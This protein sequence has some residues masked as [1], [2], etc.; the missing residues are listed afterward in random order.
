MKGIIL[1]SITGVNE[2]G[3]ITESSAVEVP[4][5]SRSNEVQAGAAMKD[6]VELNVMQSNSG[7]GN[8]AYFC[9][10]CEKMFKKKRYFRAHNLLKHSEDDS[11]RV[12][13]KENN[14]KKSQNRK[15]RTCHQ[16]FNSRNILSHIRT[17]HPELNLAIACDV[18][19]KQFK[20][21]DHMKRHK[22]GVHY[23][24]RMFCCQICERTFKRK[25]HLNSHVET[26]EPK[27]IH[28]C[29]LCGYTSLRKRDIKKH[30]C[31]HKEKEHCCEVCGGKSVSA[32]GFRAHKTRFHS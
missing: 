1:A 12:K 4:V 25:D 14:K 24:S 3:D 18:C 15:C 11:F 31:R 9:Q 17:E 27:N 20:S 8:T 30:K 21:V 16:V 32:N 29:D 5:R 23:Q 28:R 26:H 2:D 10:L 22:Q 13:A 7:N 19:E 6:Q